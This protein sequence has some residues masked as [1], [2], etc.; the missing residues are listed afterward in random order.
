MQ[1]VFFDLFYFKNGLS[2]QY[3]DAFEQCLLK[4]KNKIIVKTY[5]INF[6]ANKLY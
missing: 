3:S 6:I 2:F 4:C 5:K 1:N